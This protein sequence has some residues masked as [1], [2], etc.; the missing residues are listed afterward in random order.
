MID[1]RVIMI[2]VRKLLHSIYSKIEEGAMNAS[3]R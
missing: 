2:D 3:K 1:I